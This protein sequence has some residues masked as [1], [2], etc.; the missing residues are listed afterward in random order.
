MYLLHCFDKNEMCMRNKFNKWLGIIVMIIYLI[1]LPYFILRNLL[2]Q[3]IQDF[4][5]N[6]FGLIII[7]TFI[8]LF[9]GFIK[10]FDFETFYEELK[11]EKFVDFSFMWLFAQILFSFGFRFSF[12]DI[13]DNGYILKPAII[14]LTP[15][16]M[17]I[18]T[19]FFGR[20]IKI[21][22]M[23]KELKDKDDNL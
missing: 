20:F 23:L 9:L 18:L 15:T 16:F 12:I 3:N 7:S 17:I 4:I 22:K 1:P 19:Q 21:E 14:S 6:S 8:F 10:L 2:K 5:S 11:N 13:I